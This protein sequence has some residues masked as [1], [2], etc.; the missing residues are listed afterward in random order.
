MAEF[1]SLKSLPLGLLHI[2][3]RDLSRV[4]VW[5]TRL[6]VMLAEAEGRKLVMISAGEWREFLEAEFSHVRKR[7]VTET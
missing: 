7:M 3:V 1:R 2:G 6:A 4:P 5:Q